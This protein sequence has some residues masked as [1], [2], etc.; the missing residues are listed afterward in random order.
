MTEQDYREL[1]RFT[2]N[3]VANLGL[4]AIDERIMSVMR[5]SEG[6]L[7]DLWRSCRPQSGCPR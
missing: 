7:W 5:G 4:G 3:Q 6:A 2:R 1:L